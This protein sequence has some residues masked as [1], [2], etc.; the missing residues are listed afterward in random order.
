MMTVSRTAFCHMSIKVNKLTW[1]VLL[2]NLVN[3]CLPNVGTGGWG[4]ISRGLL[5]GKVNQWVGGLRLVRQDNVGTAFSFI[6]ALVP[7]ALAPPTPPP[8]SAQWAAVDRV[9]SDLETRHHPPPLW[10]SWFFSPS[11]G[12]SDAGTYLDRFDS[13]DIKTTVTPL[14]GLSC[15]TQ[16]S[17]AHIPKLLVQRETF[18][19]LKVFN[20]PRPFMSDQVG[21]ELHCISIRSKDNKKRRTSRKTPAAFMRYWSL[22]GQSPYR[23][24][25]FEVDV[26][27]FFSQGFTFNPYLLLSKFLLQ[28]RWT[29]K[30]LRGAVGSVVTD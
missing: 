5:V 20:L 16:N 8:T 15:C 17:W 24:L 18:G 25:R 3:L 2:M 6:K 30:P 23:T 4:G 27:V 11:C 29:S 13:H 19:H 26:E 28:S 7:P 14:Q 1:T 10:V 22:W 12:D 9:V 21:K